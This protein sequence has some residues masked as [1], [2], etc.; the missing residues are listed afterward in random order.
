[1]GAMPI[2]QPIATP[3]KGS[4]TGINSSGTVG[5]IPGSPTQA[6]A[7]NPF[8]PGAAA[9]GNTAT[10]TTGGAIVPQ[11][12]DP[13]QSLLQ[14]QETDIYGKGVGGEITSLLGSIGGVDSSSLQN[15]IASLQPQEAAAQAN[16]NT[17]LGASGVSGNSSVA[18]IADSNLQSQ[19]TAAIAGESAQLQQSGQN[20]EASILTGQEQSAAQEVSASGWS[21]FGDVLGSIGTDAAQAAG[22]I[23]KVGGFNQP[24]SSTNTGDS[25]GF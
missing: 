7:S 17:Q 15:Y 5:T 18:A 2:P 25:V 22:A 14:K 1:M 19:E 16:V 24:T 3:A 9:P 10:N 11:S 12:T 20:L 4:L 21:V 13:N 8:Q 6:P 23:A